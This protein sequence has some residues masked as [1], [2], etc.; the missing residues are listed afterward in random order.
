MQTKPLI[1]VVE[2]YAVVRRIVS[3][4][5]VQAGYEVVEA[6]DGLRAV[7]L[8]LARKPALAILDIE[9]PELNGIEALR[10]MRANGGGFDRRPRQ[11]PQRRQQVRRPLPHVVA[12]VVQVRDH[13]VG[14]VLRQRRLVGEGRLRPLVGQGRQVGRRGQ[15]PIGHVKGM[16]GCWL[17]EPARIRKRQACGPY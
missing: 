12:G 2:D 17:G 6:G 9:L 11:R 3:H 16:I 14:Q 4:V 10:R 15:H 1:L 7:E 5:L 13:P 8:A